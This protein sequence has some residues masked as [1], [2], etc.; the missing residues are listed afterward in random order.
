[1]ADTGYWDYRQATEHDLLLSPLLERAWASGRRGSDAPYLF[2]AWSKI[3]VGA[4]TPQDA[5]IGFT[6][7]F[8]PVAA[9]ALYIKSS[10]AGDVDLEVQLLVVNEAGDHEI[11]TVKTDHS[12][13]T[14]PVA[15]STKQWG[16]VA[17]YLPVAASGTITVTDVGD[18]NVFA[19]IAI[20][21]QYTIASHFRASENR[22]AELI[23][24]LQDIG[25]DPLVGGTGATLTNIAVVDGVGLVTFFNNSLVRETAPPVKCLRQLAAGETLQLNI[26]CS[27]AVEIYTHIIIMT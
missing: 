13:G 7:D 1:M 21:D 22:P 12:D 2:E 10:A 14:T 26:N 20:G 18:T 19:T 17:G 16:F 24:M 25:A 5:A 15:A 6:D 3:T 8:A 23:F 27:A 9:E 11:I 4:A